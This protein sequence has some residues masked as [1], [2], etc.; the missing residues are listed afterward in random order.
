ML[1]SSS[2]QR[3]AGRSPFPRPGHFRERADNDDCAGRGATCAGT[4]H[5]PAGRWPSEAARLRKDD[6]KDIDLSRANI[7][8]GWRTVSRNLPS[9]LHTRIWRRKALLD[10]QLEIGLVAP[11]ADDPSVSPA[12]KPRASRA[13]L[14]SRLRRACSTSIGARTCWW[15]FATVQPMRVLRKRWPS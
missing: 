14:A 11:P 12:L 6:T 5:H 13:I 10:Q 4:H 9:A 3:R 2:L 8:T 7:T 1:A 15:Q